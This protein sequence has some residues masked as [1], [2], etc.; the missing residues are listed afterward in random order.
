MGNSRYSFKSEADAT[1]KEL[2][3]DINLLKPIP[4]GE[5][6]RLLPDRTDQEQL[7]ELI[8]AVNAETDKNKRMAV[9][10]E[11]LGEVALSVKGVAEKIIAGAI[12]FA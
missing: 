12:K 3:D 9:L 5:L 2:I 8:K 11:R 1:S 10:T 7:K 6:K 4:D